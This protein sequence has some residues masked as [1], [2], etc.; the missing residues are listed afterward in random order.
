MTGRGAGSNR[1][2]SRRPGAG[3]EEPLAPASTERGGRIAP[4]GDA[5]QRYLAATGLAQ[6]KKNDAVYAAW[7]AAVGPELA[8]TARAT[9]FDRGQLVIEV[10]NSALMQEL[11][12][13]TGEA[14]RARTNE[15]LTRP[16]VRRVTFR[17]RRRT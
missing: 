14:Y 12:G 11:A 3:A 7:D 17:L 4:L 2:G 9:R 15:L 10:A 13:F 8:R 6:R 5:V 1:E 16:L